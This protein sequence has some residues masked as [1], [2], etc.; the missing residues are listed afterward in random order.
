MSCPVCR[1]AV[2]RKYS[3]KI[4]VEENILEIID[5]ECKV[6]KGKLY[7]DNQNKSDNSFNPII[8]YNNADLDKDKIIKDNKGKSGIYRWVNLTNGNSYVGSAVNLTKRFRLY[9]N[10]NSLTRDNMLVNKA[11]IK[12]GYSNF[13]LEILEYCEISN[14]VNREQYYL[15][16]IKPGLRPS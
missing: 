3:T 1:T 5:N 2:L 12:Y 6:D 15:D 4:T 13:K 10:Y 11:L 14:T 7:S 8:V 9:F 16:L